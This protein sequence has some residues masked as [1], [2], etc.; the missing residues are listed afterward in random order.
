[1][2]TGC[3]I[4]LTH[5]GLGPSSHLHQITIKHHVNRITIDRYIPD[6]CNTGD[7][8]LEIDGRYVRIEFFFWKISILL[9]EAGDSVHVHDHISGC[10]CTNEAMSIA[11]NRHSPC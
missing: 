4:F 10:A 6:E 2:V 1:M 7:A 5:W 9:S 3:V 8:G 11:V